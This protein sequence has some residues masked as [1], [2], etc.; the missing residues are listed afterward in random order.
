MSFLYPLFLY[1][2][3][4]L[5]IP[6]I[7]HL[8]NFRKTRRVYYSSTQFLKNIKEAST[9]S[10][11][12]KHWLILASR[13]FFL[14]FLVLAFAQPF[15]PAQQHRSS[16]PDV[17]IYLDNSASMTNEVGTDFTALDAGLS[18]INQLPQLFAAGT[19]YKLLTNDFSSFS[20][21]F[22]SC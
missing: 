17:Y 8:F 20:N 21:F 2:L 18:F 12:I 5:S 19:R 13:L 1:G 9:S 14:T 3:L 11:K 7:I 4:A 6:I 16:D 10:L 22:N 15:I